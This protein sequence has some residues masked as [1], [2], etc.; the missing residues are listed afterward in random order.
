MIVP[1]RPVFARVL[2][3]DD[4]VQQLAVRAHV[5]KASGLSVITACGPIEAIWILA[6]TMEE[7]DVAI[8][9]YDM[10]VMN[11]CILAR[12]IR[13]ICP[14]LKIILYSGA[15]Y[16]PQSKMTSVDAFIPKGDGVGTLI[17]YVVQLAQATAGADSFSL[18][19]MEA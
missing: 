5:M 8:L 16:I 19:G 11:G 15:V 6:G 13:S 1:R 2:L 3:V 12:R 7:I 18:P 17:N 10:P 9:D 14:W 4:E